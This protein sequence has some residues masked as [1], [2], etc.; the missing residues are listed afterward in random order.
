VVDYGCLIG[1]V[2][3]LKGM[4]KVGFNEADVLPLNYSRLLKKYIAIDARCRFVPVLKG[5]WFGGLAKKR[6]TA[7]SVLLSAKSALQNPRSNS[8]LLFAI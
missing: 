6:P 8:E 5:P 7:R 4:T 1:Y 2:Q 3:I